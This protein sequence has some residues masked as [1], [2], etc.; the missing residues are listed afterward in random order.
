M[1][2]PILPVMVAVIFIIILVTILLK[3]LD[4][5]NVIAYIIAGFLIGPYGFS[6][7]TNQT[8]ISRLGDIGVIMLLFFIG[9]EVPLEKIISKW[10]VAVYGTLLQV[11][12]SVLFIY[13][14]SYFLNWSLAKAILWGFVISLSSTAVII[15][16]L[17]D[18]KEIDTKVGQNVLS[19]L[20]AQDIIVIPMFI[21]LT[22]LG[23]AEINSKEILFQIIGAIII[24]LFTIW[25]IKR[26]TNIQTPFLKLMK[27][28][29]ELQVF[30]GLLI[31]FSFAMISGFFGLSTAL[32]SFIAGLTISNTNEHEWIRK[33]LH[34]FYVILVAIFF[35][36]IGMLI[37][38]EFLFEHFYLILFLVIITLLLKTFFN[39]IIL[40]N[41][42]NNWADSFYAGALLSQIG[43]FSFILGSI[44]FSLGII[45]DYGY[46]LTLTVIAL[47]LLI[48]PFWIFIFKKYLQDK[49][50]NL[51]T[52]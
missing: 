29:H 7:I 3:I 6:I 31:C 2:D 44:G 19:I 48:C 45:T 40:K 52:L 14:L 50:K 10:K 39:A 43:E 17:E 11:L 36:S 33:N 51:D 4:Q 26:K 5:P 9:M 47:T 22:F 8:I 16:V 46:Q 38:S 23:G 1:L 42:E 13:L 30:A 20:I 25:L 18:M 15:K 28:D 24:I 21:I 32:G 35:V 37:N 41:L 34:P 27:R 49:V 12:G